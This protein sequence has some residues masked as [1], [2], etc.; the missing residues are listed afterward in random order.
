MAC[1]RMCIGRSGL[2]GYFPDLYAGNVYAGCLYRAMRDAVPG[3]DVGPCGRGYDAGDR[4]AARTRSSAH[5]RGFSSRARSSP[6]PAG[7]EP[8]E[9]PLL[10]YLTEKFGGLYGL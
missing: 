4:L 5:A 2:F 7:V 10:D 1:C 6:A 9:Q 3:L 8:D